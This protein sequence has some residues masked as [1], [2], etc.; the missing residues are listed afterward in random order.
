MVDRFDWNPLEKYLEDLPDSLYKYR[1]FDE[2][3]YG[4]HLAAQG[5]AHFACPTAFN[6][7]YEC[8]LIPTSEMLHMRQFA[9]RAA[10]RRVT[11]KY[12]PHANRRSRRELT[13]LAESRARRRSALGNRIE[14]DL[15]DM[16]QQKV[17]VLSMAKTYKSIPMWAYYAD[18]QRGFCVGLSVAAI[19]EY[20]R[21]VFERAGEL[22]MLYTASYQSEIPVVNIDVPEN[23]KK[24]DIEAAMIPFFTKGKSWSHE[25]EVRLLYWQN[26]GRTVTFG[27]SAVTKIIVGASACD[28]S[29]QALVAKLR[30]AGSC[31]PIFRAKLSVSSY[32]VEIAPLDL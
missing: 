22:L 21:Q 19:A 10:L 12:I 26:A 6:D 25:D 24:E 9:R 18:N 23:F 16:H 17:G 7:P 5:E 32:S 8:A 20:Q 13:R 15:V 3:G 1:T 29:I 11:E 30:D 4:I 28:R 31:A 27:T 14:Q 2:D